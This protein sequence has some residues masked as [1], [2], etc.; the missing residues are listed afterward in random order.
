MTRTMLLATT[1]A[2]TLWS[3]TTAPPDRRAPDAWLEYDVIALQSA[4]DAGQLSAAALVDFYLERI[5]RLDR[6]GPRLGSILEL[7]PD[8]REIASNLDAERASRGPRGLLHGIPI[9]LKANIDTGDAMATTAGSRALAGHI[10]P[11]DAFLVR[12]LRD[13]GAVILGKANLS[14]WANFRSTRSSSGWSSLGGQTR[15]PYDPLRNPCGSSSGSGVAVAANLAVLAVGTE[16]DGSIVCPASING[17][18][19]IKPTLG[20]VSRDGIIPIAHSQDTAGPMARTVMD[21]ALML[22][23]MSGFDTDDPATA[24]RPQAIP[25]FASGLSVDGLE[26]KRIGVIRNYT[27]AGSNPYVDESFANAIQAMRDAGATIV[28]G[29]EPDTE[30]LGA[31]EYEVLLF[32]FKADL[33]RYFAASGAPVRTL[34]DVIAY[35]EAHA[36]EVMPFFGQEHMLAADEKG[37]LSDTAYQEALETSKR[38][39]RAAI[40]TALAEHELD[41]LVAPSNGPAWMTDHVNG[42][43]FGIGSSSLAAVSGYASITVPSGYVFDLPVGVSFI[44]GAFSELELIRLAYAFEQ[45]TTARRAPELD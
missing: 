43:S 32:E 17:I 42:D 27:G 40:D 29:I 24:S 6:D 36:A 1:L 23:A 26:G 33:A 14:E 3:C 39:A 37:D 41:A 31:A 20:L 18:V 8:A 35:N 44:G 45:A 11:D 16:T 22:N 10:A 9:V 30:G 19:G 28:D 38:V 2:L 15:N 4:M 34:G 25:D 5:E 13:A 21:A 12:Q 7:N